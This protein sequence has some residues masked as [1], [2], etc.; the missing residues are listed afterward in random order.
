[1]IVWIYVWIYVRMI[2]CNIVSVIVYIYVCMII[3]VIMYMISVMI[4]SVITWDIGVVILLSITFIKTQT[5]LTL[6]CLSHSII[7]MY[8]PKKDTVNCAYIAYCDIP[9]YKR[10]V[11]YYT[12]IYDTRP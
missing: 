6:Y 8:T 4:S 10:V 12:A 9:C 1:M 7:I 11:V 2:M 5:I 3:V